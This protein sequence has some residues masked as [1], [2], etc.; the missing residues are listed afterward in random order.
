MNFTDEENLSFGEN[1]FD[2]E[3]LDDDVKSENCV[4]PL[5]ASNTN[6]RI[7]IERISTL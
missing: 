2:G 5:I 3:K 6:T 1:F 7:N 4:K